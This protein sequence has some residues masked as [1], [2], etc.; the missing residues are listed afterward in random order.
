LW[1]TGVGILLAIVGVIL[2]IPDP[3]RAKIIEWI[4]SRW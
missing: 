3:Y 1:L 2:A 4:L